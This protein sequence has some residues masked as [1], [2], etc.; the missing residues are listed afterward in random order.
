MT[1]LAPKQE[2][3][4]KRMDGL[5]CL[6][7]S[8]WE[9]REGSFRHLM[10]PWGQHLPCS[11]SL[12]WVSRGR[13]RLSPPYPQTRLL[14]QMEPKWSALKEQT[15]QGLPSNLKLGPAHKYDTRNSSSINF[16]FPWSRNPQ[17]NRNQMTPKP[18]PP[19]QMT[20]KPLPPTERNRQTTSHVETVGLI[21][22]TMRLRS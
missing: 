9:C 19:N 12:A 14:K 17:S 4:K 3:N 10:H 1:A 6:S 20:P 13:L 8:V 5:S 16:I 22:L 11:I 2:N 15:P 7:P 21:P 18:W